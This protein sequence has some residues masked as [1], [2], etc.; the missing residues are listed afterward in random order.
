[1]KCSRESMLLYA[2]TDRTWLGD[3]TLEEQTEAA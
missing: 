3:A 1:M 2:V